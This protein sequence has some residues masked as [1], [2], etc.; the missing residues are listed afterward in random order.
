M[1]ADLAH[2]IDV[3]AHG[4]IA[5]IEK[6]EGWRVELDA[7]DELAARL[8][9]GK[10]IVLGLGALHARQRRK[11]DQE[12]G[13]EPAHVTPLPCG[14]CGRAPLRAPRR[15]RRARGGDGLGRRVRRWSL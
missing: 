6:T 12:R 9:G 2:E 3:E 15:C 1:L 5:L 13:E 7:G 14:R 10:R 4:L 11:R 8:D